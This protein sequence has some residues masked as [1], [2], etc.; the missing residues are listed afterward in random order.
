MAPPLLP[1]QKWFL[2]H[3]LELNEDR[4]FRFR[5]LLLLVAR[6]NGKT[7]LLVLLILWRMVLDGSPLV[8]GTAQNLD[9]AEEAWAKAVAI[10]EAIPDLEAIKAKVSKVNGKH[11]L[12]LT[13]KARY[14]VQAAT[15]RGGRGFSG[16]LVILDELREHQTWDAWSAVSK[17]TM[18]RKRAQAIGASNAGDI[19]SIVLRHLRKVAIDALEGRKPNEAVEIDGEEIE[20]DD[21]SLGIFE[22]SA[23]DGRAVTDRDGWAEANPSLGYTITEKAIAAACK[24]DPEWI[25]RTEVL[26]QFV[27]T[28]K[29]GP[30]PEGKW[31]ATR[32]PASRRL[33]G[34][35]LYACVDTSHNRTMTY[36]AIAA[37]REDGKWHVE[38]IAARAGTD[39]V[40]P[41]FKARPGKFAAITM[42]TKGAPVSSLVPEF[43]EAGITLVE[44]AAENLG[45]ASGILYDAVNDEKLRHRDQPA[46]DIAAVSALTK[47]AGDAWLIDRKNS[48]EDAAPLV[49]IAAALWLMFTRPKPKP[50]PRIRVIGG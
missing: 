19:A 47:P 37:V 48:P 45:R 12:T 18:A 28:S 41:W 44:W 38:I 15:R 25:F 50:V 4:S 27:N 9:V 1:W 7:F 22:W 43:E 49:C 17:T 16:D 29:G 14:K 32:D 34:A 39:W 42:Q 24:T 36:I 31:E 35:P 10:V 13:N 30:F 3:A 21:D 40:L 26:C 11:S 23:A 8:I 20:I 46:L 33:E 5:T 6:Q 2:I